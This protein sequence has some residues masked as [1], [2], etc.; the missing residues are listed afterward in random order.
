MWQGPRL[1]PA[2]AA[3]LS[4][5]P[6]RR[7]F[8]AS[9]ASPRSLFESSIRQRAGITTNTGRTF[10]TADGGE[11]WGWDRPFAKLNQS[12]F[13]LIST[14]FL[15]SWNDVVF[16]DCIYIHYA[17]TYRMLIHSDSFQPLLNRLVPI[18]SFCS[19]IP[20]SSACFRRRLR[21]LIHR[22]CEV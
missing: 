18:I 7:P 9:K 17:G 15:S 1:E 20:S 2:C 16:I 5:R 12:V 10:L 3:A 21:L 11:N 22:Y 4:M 14:L 6:A 19:N 8:N 13:C